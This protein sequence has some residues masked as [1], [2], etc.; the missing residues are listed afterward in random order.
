MR[1]DAQNPADPPGEGPGDAAE[2]AGANGA[3]GAGG[4]SRG[5]SRRAGE[6]GSGPK[7]WTDK[8][9][10]ATADELL[11]DLGERRAGV[12]RV[13]SL[14]LAD[15]QV[16][17]DVSWQGVSWRWS[18]VYTRP[19]DATRAWAYLVPDPD[20]PRICV[21]LPEDA[22]EQIRMR[23]LKK[24]AREAVLQAQ[25]VAGVRWVTL[26]IGGGGGPGGAAASGVGVEE[27]EEV[28][29]AKRECRGCCGRGD[30][31]SSN[32]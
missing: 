26:E 5:G 2:S 31:D 8:F 9:R 14:L 22:V 10:P 20:E 25:M 19:G 27:I 6:E 16:A 17:E 30:S 18:L 3:A 4:G 28:L 7:R 29:R 24:G 23:R 15:R 21:P 13:R 32:L 11:S 12:E 1:N